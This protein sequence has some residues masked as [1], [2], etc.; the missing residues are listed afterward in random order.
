MAT[1]CV[2]KQWLPEFWTKYPAQNFE[3][4]LFFVY[5]G[6]NAVPLNDFKVTTFI[7]FPILSASSY[8]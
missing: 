5:V 6:I 7:M 3:D 1:V 4:H 2:Y 8:V